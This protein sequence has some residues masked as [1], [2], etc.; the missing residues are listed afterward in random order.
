MTA[1]SLAYLTK[2]VA[3]NASAS[4]L[5][6]ADG[7][8]TEAK[9]LLAAVRTLHSLIDTGAMMHGV[10]VSIELD[11]ALPHGV[12]SGDVTRDMRAATYYHA[13][14]TVNSYRLRR[15]GSILVNHSV[16]SEE[17]TAGELSYVFRRA[18]DE[19]FF[20][21]TNEHLVSEPEYGPTCFGG[22]YFETLDDALIHYGKTMV[23]PMACA[24]LQSAWALPE[25]RILLANKPEHIMRESLHQY[26]VSSLRFEENV[27]VLP[28][29]NVDDTHPVDI[30][31]IWDGA[32][33]LAL[34]EIKW[35]GKSLRRT[36][37]SVG[38]K[39]SAGRARDGLKQL[40]D[41]IDGMTDRA[42]WSSVMGYLA[43]F[44]ARRHGASA[45][46]M[47]LTRSNALRY[48]NEAIDYQPDLLAR[49]D[50]RAPVRWFMA[51]DDDVIVG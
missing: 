47:T 1:L 45:G 50:V 27:S 22:L 33:R 48:A 28:E 4:F 49:H 26:L 23:E 40:T 46:T 44:D 39:W 12:M 15:D 30:K 19:V 41:Y 21:P 10:Y 16:G 32:R 14:D 9:E 3:N 51:P 13:A 29:Q 35:L 25:A 18:R 5:E 38:S 7:F 42:A 24:R 36:G 20:T 8:R 6:K 31:V 34:I 2:L 11:T 37:R 17:S 43:V